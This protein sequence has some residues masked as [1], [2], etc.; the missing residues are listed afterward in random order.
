MTPNPHFQPHKPRPFLS[1]TLYIVDIAVTVALI[2]FLVRLLGVLPEIHYRILMILSAAYGLVFFWK[3]GLQTL[4]KTSDLRAITKVWTMIVGT[5]LITLFASKTAQLYSR[6]VLLCWFCITPIILFAI[7]SLFRM[8]IRSPEPEEKTSQPKITGCANH[9]PQTT[10]RRES[11][12]FSLA[13]C[14]LIGMGSFSAGIYIYAA[15]KWPYPMI[16]E[17]EQFM[18]GD[19]GESTTLLEKIQNDLNILPSRHIATSQ[20]TFHIPESYP[21]LTQLPL[22]HH[23]QEP[24]LYISDTAPKGYRLIYGTFDFKK[25]LHGAVLFGPDGTV[26]NIW[27]I[28]QNDVEWAHPSDAN[29]FP[30]GFVI[31]P[32]GSIVTAFDGGTSLT[33]YD[34]SGNIV[35]R[36]K[37][38]FHHSID[39]DGANDIWTW[40]KVGADKPYGNNLI[41]IDYSTGKVLKEFLI[42]DVM[43]ANPDID[44]FGIVQEDTIEGSKWLS[45]KVGG[46]WHVNDIDPLPQDLAQYY[47]AFTP[48]DLL[49]SLRSPDLVCVIDPDTYRVKWWRQGLT[50]RQH[51]PDWNTN[52]TITIF[53][54]N[55][56]KDYSN[57]TEVDPVTYQ[58][59]NVV[60]G[61]D[62]EFY[63]VMRGKHQALPNGG[64][65]ITSPE[66][67]RVFEVDSNGEITFEFINRF[68]KNKKNLAVSE[69]VFLPLDFFK[70]LP[71]R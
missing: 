7:H 18:V 60:Q 2:P 67:G 26:K 38:G 45:Y 14:V 63:T 3:T 19:P 56:H 6:A 28:S 53:N 64:S 58:Y 57:I 40:G 42:D 68:S 32:D 44:I 20:K 47:P 59:R 31:A 49:L 22:K 27:H 30:H 36:I 35:W 66:Q 8:M 39:F 71:D 62:Y 69:A 33:K 13:L 46:Q 37:G 70:D 10:A 21:P 4:P 5:L 52:G 54:N 16:Q 15:K 48:G 11:I 12:L 9:V 29:V 17:L 25:S 41:K 65:L 55:M 43:N 34:Y 51:D 1:A 24:L 23:R 61:K 50:R